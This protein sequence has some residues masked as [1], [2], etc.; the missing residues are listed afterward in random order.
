MC[1]Q[2]FSKLRTSLAGLY[3]ARGRPA[4][5]ERAFLQALKLYPFSPE[6]AFRLAD[7]YLSEGRFD[8]ARKLVA[9]FK[10]GDPENDRLDDFDQ[11]V[12]QYEA[13]YRNKQRLEAHE[14]AG[15]STTAERYELVLYYRDFRETEKMAR[16][17]ETVIKSPAPA[18]TRELLKF[19]Y[20][21]EQM[22]RTDLVERLLARA[23]PRKIPAMRKPGCNWPLH[24][25]SE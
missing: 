21:C 22:S 19:A 12:T 25:D 14:T 10:K 1:S 11:Y 17:I 6:A 4:E 2:S 9:E 16:V 5:S 13:A 18:S 23:L 15:T 3:A 24:N 7:F 8:D 20:L